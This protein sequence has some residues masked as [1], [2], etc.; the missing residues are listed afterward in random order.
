MHR[1]GASKLVS[2]VRAKVIE[3]DLERL[4]PADSCDISVFEFFCGE[5]YLWEIAFC[6]LDPVLL[7][8]GIRVNYLM[9]VLQIA[10]K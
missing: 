3:L 9:V 8:R 5:F 6:D 2:I 1:T 10:H 7:F 4:K